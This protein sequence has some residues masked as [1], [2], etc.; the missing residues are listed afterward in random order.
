MSVRSNLRIPIRWNA[1]CFAL[2]IAS[3]A[4]AHHSPYFPDLG[5]GAVRQRTLDAGNAAVVLSIAAEPGQEDLTTLTVLRM[6]EGARVTSAFLTNGGATPCDR[7]DDL[8]VRLAAR[9]KVEAYRAASLLGAETYF[10]NF[11]DFGVAEGKEEL[12]KLWG[13]DSLVDRCVRAIRT[14]KPDLILIARDWRAEQGDPARLAIMKEVLT[15]AVAAAGDTEGTSWQGLPPWSVSR[16]M[17]EDPEGT[18]VF[19]VEADRRIPVWKKSYREI[20]RQARRCYESL[21]PDVDIRRAADARRY[22]MVVPGTAG[23]MS[24]PAF[25]LPP[26]TPLLRKLAPSVR[27]A[28]DEAAAGHREKAVRSIFIALAETEGVM[29]GLPLTHLEKRVIG[30][31]RNALEDLRCSLLGIGLT[32]A[33]SDSLLA[34]RQL[35]FL[36]FKSLKGVTTKGQSE[37]IFPSAMNGEWYINER[38]VSRFPFTAPSE[39]RILTPEK[40]Q[41]N[42]PVALNGLDDPSIRTS[43]PFI[44][45]HRSTDSLRSFAYRGELDLGI[46]PIRAIEVLTPVVRVTPGERCVVAITNI[47]RDPFGGDVW[48]GDSVVNDSRSRVL[49]THKDEVLNDTLTLAWKE[50]VPDGDHLIQLHFNKRTFGRFMARKFTVEADTA[51]HDGLLA[52]GSTSAL[53]E[54]LRRLHVPCTMLDSAGLSRKAFAAFRVVILDQ[55]ALDHRADIG[56]IQGDLMS[57]VADGGRLIVMPQHTSLRRGTEGDSMAF[58][59]SLLS[60]HAQVWCDSSQ[61]LTRPNAISGLDWSDWI[62]SRSWRAIQTGI[63][64]RIVVHVRA[65]T[66]G[67]PLL[68]SEAIGKGFVIAVA[69]DITPQLE[70]IHEGTFRIFANLISR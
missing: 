51:R 25:G 22:D 55:D 26:L 59:P 45:F 65:V 30:S 37:I 9:R 40:M 43:F 20:A 63:D 27:Q 4:A 8:P 3:H 6:G 15:L 54:A 47:S 10:L 11:P 44:I 38:D 53:R 67:A 48:A 17:Q 52:V 7:G 49:L 41:L 31:W 23:A 13:K 29:R 57:W 58:V 42:S 68:V 61:L 39:F 32:Y 1:L 21:G 2:L 46:G 12:E 50:S 62:I 70:T 19:R 24:S 5:P 56:A 16:V 34:E 35:F 14:V 36:R 66:T 33:A 18:R 69:L 28:T 64:P 60:P